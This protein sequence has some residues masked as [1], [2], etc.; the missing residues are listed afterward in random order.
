MGEPAVDRA[1]IEPIAAR[2]LE[3]ER[4]KRIDEV[5]WFATAVNDVERFGLI[6]SVDRPLH[7]GRSRRK[8][9]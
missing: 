5:D 3:R 6:G 8:R 9:L 1:R 2:Q 4:G 7:F